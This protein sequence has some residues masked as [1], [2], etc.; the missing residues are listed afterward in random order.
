MRHLTTVFL[1]LFLTTG[2]IF[3]ICNA[4]VRSKRFVINADSTM[5]KIIGD[6]VTSVIEN[7]SKIYVSRFEKGNGSMVFTDIKS[8]KNDEK[9]LFQFL[10]LDKSMTTLAKPAFYAK[11]CP[12]IKIECFDSRHHKVILFFDIALGQWQ[13]HQES[14][15]LT[16]NIPDNRFARFFQ[17]LF[18]EDEAI[19][20]HSNTIQ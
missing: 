18:P 13:M 9:K 2:C 20:I 12:M 14:Q 16:F 10:F 11:F 1:L 6:S 17:M 4:K 7:A 3:S 19:K 15:T 5:T 8:L